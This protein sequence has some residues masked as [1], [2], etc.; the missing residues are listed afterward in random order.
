MMQRYIIT[1][2]LKIMVAVSPSNLI[3]STLQFYSLYDRSYQ[4]SI[5]DAARYGRVSILWTLQNIGA[6]LSDVR[7]NDNEALRLASANGHAIVLVIFRE[8][9]LTLQDARSN[10]NE[11]LRNAATNG[12]L[13]VLKYLRKW[14]ITSDEAK[15]VKNPHRVV[16]TYLEEWINSS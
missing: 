5:S 3:V 14:G 4:E 9:G 2:I 11:A 13:C 15:C 7:A 8:W 6:T 12:H 10:D 16:S 1:L